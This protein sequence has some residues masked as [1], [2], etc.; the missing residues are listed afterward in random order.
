[1]DILKKLLNVISQYS[2]HIRI[3]KRLLIFF[4]L[5]SGVPLLSVGI[6]SY[7]K[8]SSAVQT[9]T[10]SYSSEIM[11]QFSQNI[12][13]Y[14]FFIESGGRELIKSK[15]FSNIINEYDQGK[16]SE[17][18][19]A[20]SLD[21]II[22]QKISPSVI[23]GCEAALY[24]TKSHFLAGASGYHISS[25]FV[26]MEKEFE[27]IA[28]QA[29]GKYTW[30]IKKGK[31][32]E[33]TYIIA[34]VQIY[35]ELSNTPLGALAIF[36]NDSYI[37][38]IY[39]SISIEGSKGIFI[40]DSTGTVI[41]SNSQSTVKTNTQYSNKGLVNHL[42]SLAQDTEASTSNGNKIKKGHLYLNEKGTNFLYLYAQIPDSNWFVVSNIPTTF[43]RSESLAIRN[44]IL[45][46]SLFI[47]ILAIV[48]SIFI[49]R[50]IS[51]PLARLKELM[52][53]AKEGNLDISIYDNF[54]DE[55]SDLSNN[56]NE[57]VENIRQLVTKVNAS[58][59]QVLTSAEKLSEMSYAYYTS[60]EQVAISMGQISEGASSQAADN[61]KALGH[62]TALSDDIKRVSK[63][64]EAVSKIIYNTK[65]LSKNALESVEIL[66][67][68][69]RQTSKV[70]EEIVNQINSFYT[71]M[72]EI[73]KIVKFI[74]GISEQTNLLSLNAAIEAARAGDAGKGFAVVAEE[75]RKLADQTNNSL[76]SINNSIQ[77]IQ[78]KADI[79]FIS[80]NKT[81]EIVEDQLNAVNDT[82]NSFK[83]IFMSMENIIN[84][85]REFEIS[86]SKILESSIKSLEAI[87]DISTVSEETAATV[88]EITT[89]TQ[90]QIEGIS[91][92]SS[93]S[94]LLSQMA[95][96]LN[97]SISYFKI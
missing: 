59:N 90:Q 74:G 34:V 63:D 32:N 9:K 71:D 55:I 26:G 81:K 92:V 30:L 54:S 28:E 60:S 51:T 23:D 96:E 31:K 39:K 10:Q 72:K 21:A 25:E 43:I 1:M 97:S 95:Q 85:T 15:E 24:I 88:E 86:V 94:K 84:I 70:S 56:F 48:I 44:T 49:S 14:L 42:K 11:S 46:V 64:M 47:F 13:N 8:S 77:N 76:T 36:L 65:Y 6:L 83:E 38:N 12:K 87:N 18:D 37:G 35:N 78:S 82:D 3:Q 29:K 19:A 45:Y 7:S 73:Q 66:N 5:L 68:K 17:N 53:K 27:T 33:D 22:I 16:I 4:I 91:E 93:Q 57:M 75:V 89:T 40:A 62:V 20:Q 52:K 67:E 41:S 79:T 80:A 2:R 58:S 61:H 69:S 50:G